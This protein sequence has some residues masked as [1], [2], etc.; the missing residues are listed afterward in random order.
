M[1]KYSH[2]Q[3]DETFSALSD[4]TRRGILARLAEGE[5]QAGDL[6]APFGIS[7][8]AVSKHLKVL[9]KAQLIRRRRE[10]RVHRFTVNPQP[11]QAAMS[12]VEQYRGFWEQQL[13]ALEG[14][15]ESASDSACNSARKAEREK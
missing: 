3:L 1:V 5:A 9:E 4:P 12:W 11:M 2:E 7:L 15:L 14:Y 6:A 13:V 10:G 8:P